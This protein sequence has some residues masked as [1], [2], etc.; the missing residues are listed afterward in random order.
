[1]PEKKVSSNR[2][3]F[4]PSSL[5]GKFILLTTLILAITLGNYSAY[6]YMDDK[7][8]ALENLKNRINTLGK[9]AVNIS[10]N[11]ILSYDFVALNIFM[12]NLTID[13]EIVYAVMLAPD[14]EPM[15][16]HIDK[17]NSFISKALNNSPKIEI[18][19]LL[20]QVIKNEQVF[21]E[22]FPVVIDSVTAAVIRLGI[23]TKHIDDQSFYILMR[24]LLISLFIIM[25]L[26]TFIYIV[27]RI[28]TLRPIIQL[29]QGAKRIADGNLDEEVKMYSEDELGQLTI[30]FNQMMHKLSRSNQEKDQ[31]LLQLT[32]FNKKLESRVQERTMELESLNSNLEYIALHDS[33]TGLPNRVLIQDRIKQTIANAKRDKQTFSILTMDL[34]R[35]KEVNDALGHECGDNLLIE[36]SNRIRDEIRDRD[37]VGRLGGDEFALILV[38]TNADQAVI[39]ANKLLKTLEPAFHIQ[40]MAFS[41]SSSIGISA[42]PQHGFDVTTLMKAADVAMYAA[43]HNR[44]GYCI[45]SESVDQ[46]NPDNLS[47]MGELRDAINNNEL[48]LHY[49]PKVDLITH[50]IIGVEALVRWIHKTRGFIPPDSFIPLAEQTGLIKPLAALVLN[51]ALQQCAA[52]EKKGIDISVSVNLS[53]YNIQD[54][55]TPK[56]LTSLMNKWQVKKNQLVLE[57]TESTIMSNPE[58]VMLVLKQ[59]ESMGISLSI[60]DFGTGY[61]SLSNLKKLPVH[62]L[63]ID[64]SFVMDM[65]SDKDDK[66]IVQSIV[67]MAHTMGLKVV[68][69]GVETMDVTTQL[70]ELGCDI[71][72]GYFISKPQPPEALENM[73]KN[74][75]WIADSN[76]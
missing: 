61:S 2:M 67:Q 56:L 4:I 26:C 14:G 39:V 20:Q 30:S 32:D 17:E 7:S 35:F 8:H 65:S 62:E 37:T 72:Q 42:Y 71:I 9:F 22:K 23:S 38:N 40:D 47:I 58:S 60:D 31:A 27:F 63:K 53:M 34:D 48:E 43:K 1:M 5:G 19:Q 50:E 75:H 73:L 55:Q 12:E 3:F 29:M 11:A 36:V 54:V 33:L 46:N 70:S 57:I 76:N 74:K 6:N 68:A 64:R 24:Q 16:S 59:I 18:Q 69:E 52:W 66:A 49:Q 15:T 44:Q 45:Y 10:P 41:I 28:N 51:K 21:E 25:T 13:E